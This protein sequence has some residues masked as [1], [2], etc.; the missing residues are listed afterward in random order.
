[1]Y[2]EGMV[3]GSLGCAQ[4]VLGRWAATPRWLL[5]AQLSLMPFLF[6]LWPGFL[7]PHLG[8]CG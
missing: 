7:S 3:H 1:M 8:R 2:S 6:S 4:G 5:R